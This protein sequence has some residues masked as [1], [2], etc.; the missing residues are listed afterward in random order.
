MPVVMAVF[1]YQGTGARGE[2]RAGEI[3]APSRS[4]ALRRLAM[5]RIQPLTLVAKADE[6][7]AKPAKNHK[8]AAAV[9]RGREHASGHV[10]L[11][12]AQVIL[13]TDEL[14][15]F[16]HSGLQ[17]EPALQLMENREESSP[18]KDVSKFLREKVRDGTSFSEALKVASPNFDELYCNLVAAGE[19]SGAMAPLL[20][21]QAI[22]LVA[23]Q[24]L[25]GRVKLALIYPA[26][27]VL[28]GAAAMVVFMTVLV[29]QM[30]KLFSKT[31]SAMPLPTYVLVQLSAGLHKYGLFGGA[32]LGI[33]IAGF[34]AYIRQPTGRRW[35]DETK[36]RLPLLGG[37]LSASFYAQFCQTMANLLQ[38]GLPLLTA[39][40]LMSRATGNVFYRAL[41]LRITDLVGEG[42]SLTRAMKAVGHFPA[43]L[44]DLVKVGESTGDLGSTLEKIGERYE[45]I[46]QSRIDR[47]MSI[48]PLII[49]AALGL[50][51]LLIAWSMLS[52]IFQAMR[53]LQGHG[54]H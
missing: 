25:R 42:A 53:G 1:A 46:I 52:G 51:V 13:F 4:E 9:T 14:S 36:L 54:H 8:A 37:L 34:V 48:V 32:V 10:R 19:V 44:R 30:I 29:P 26:A 40:K 39:L 21:R 2:K 23:M 45:K 5:D 11:S 12:N 28:A 3:D 47:I 35:W 16:L 17:L 18:V 49:I 27:L 33:M 7:L 22:H 24:D 38:N 15:D 31:G 50:M 41:L 43:N 20:R 6:A